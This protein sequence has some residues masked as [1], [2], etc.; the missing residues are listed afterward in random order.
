MTGVRVAL[1]QVG[2]ERAITGLQAS[3][4]RLEVKN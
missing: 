3:C 1:R 4:A 2:G